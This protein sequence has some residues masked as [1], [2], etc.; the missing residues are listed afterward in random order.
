MIIRPTSL[1]GAVTIDV[2]PREDERGFFARTFCE[3]EFEAAGL[4]TRFHQ[5]NTSFNC[6]AGTLRGLHFQLP[7]ATEAKLV[8]CT[9][10]AIFDVIVDLR[11][12]A[13]TFRHWHG[14]NLSAA[15]RRALFVPAGFAH[16]F[17]TLT[18]AS[19]VFY[20]M[21]GVPDERLARG[22]RFDDPALGIHW[23]RPP[24]VMSERDRNWPAFDRQA[25][26]LDGFALP[27]PA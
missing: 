2:E 9:A 16:G 12:D 17:I 25:A 23:P 8:R 26:D 7:P 22:L 6:L 13:P 21:H 3:Q 11:P 24:A 1:P 10:G 5:S 18:D 4:P 15:N 20:M 19:E 27:E 14:E